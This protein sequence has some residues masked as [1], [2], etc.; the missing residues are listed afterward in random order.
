VLANPLVESPQTSP[1]DPTGL[2]VDTESRFFSW[3][4]RMWRRAK[5]AADAV[6][7]ISDLLAD[8]AV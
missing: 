1:S 2:G 3:G 7:G 6:S 5:N 4:W 8:P